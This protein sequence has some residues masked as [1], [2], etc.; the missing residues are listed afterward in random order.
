MTEKKLCAKLS[1]RSYDAMPVLMSP[2]EV[3]A[4]SVAVS[5][6]PVLMSP[7]EADMAKTQVNTRVAQRYRRCFTTV[8]S[9]N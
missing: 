8:Y 6:L 9:C 7:A 1:R 2:V 4:A 3:V 5:D